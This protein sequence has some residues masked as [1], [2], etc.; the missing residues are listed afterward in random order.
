[1]LTLAITGFLPC[2]ILICLLC[3]VL[4]PSS[5]SEALSHPKW[6]QATT[7]EMCALQSSGTWELISLLPWKSIVGCQWLYTLKIGPNGT[8][9]HIKAR[10]V[11]KGCTWVY[12]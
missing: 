1:M 6:R 4:I 5:P 9:D 7:D 8:I 12:G 11:A 10:L 2:I 3:L